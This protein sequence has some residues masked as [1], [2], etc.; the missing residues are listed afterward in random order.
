VSHG[1]SLLEGGNAL[2]VR[3]TGFLAANAG[4]HKPRSSQT[5]FVGRVPTASSS[6]QSGCSSG[7]VRLFLSG[8]APC[9]LLSCRRCSCPISIIA[10]PGC[11]ADITASTA[12]TIA[13]L[14]STYCSCRANDWFRATP[15]R[16]TIAQIVVHGCAVSH[17]MA[18]CSSTE[19]RLRRA[20]AGKRSMSAISAL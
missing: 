6:A 7:H 13:R 15:C 18:A 14:P 1:E 20:G 2:P 16:R 11:E 10:V 5:V 9:P 4:R 17:V 3:G 19:R 12:L 8:P